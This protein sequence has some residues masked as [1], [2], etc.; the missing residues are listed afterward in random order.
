ML[1]AISCHRLLNGFIIWVRENG[2]GVGVVAG[3]R[4]CGEWKLE[5]HLAV[6][7]SLSIKTVMIGSPESVARV[8]CQMGNGEQ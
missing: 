7:L 6:L 3:W 2:R 1:F 5:G 4:E 8:R